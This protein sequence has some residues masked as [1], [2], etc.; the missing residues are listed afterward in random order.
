MLG[1]QDRWQEELFVACSLR[2]LI[3]EDHILKRVE[4]VLDLSWLR[5]EVKDCYCLDNGR[6][7]VDPESAVRLMLA[8]LFQGIIHD[9]KLM[10]EAQVNVAIRW[11]A[12]YRLDEKLPDHS[13]LTKIRRRWGA[14]RFK[15]IFLRTVKACGGAG[16]VS[17]EMTHIDAKL[18][19]AD[20]SWESLVEHH[21][22]RVLEE[23]DMEDDPNDP[24]RR[25]KRG[26]PRTKAPKPKKYS[27]TD[28]DATLTTNNK[29]VRMEPYY[30]QHT[31]VDDQAG[32]VVDV[33]VTTGQANEGEQL[34]EQIN[35]VEANT[36]RKV[37]AVT[38]DASY[39]HSKN[40]LALENRQIDAV[41]PPQTESR[42]PKRIPI[43]R[44]KY[45][46]RHKVVRCPGG[47]VLQ[48]SSYTSKRW[49]YRAATAD[50]RACPLRKRC[51]SPS[52]SSRTIVIAHGYEALLRAR[53]RKAIGW[54]KPTR[55]AYCRHR[56]RAE[57]VHGEAAK[58]HNLGRAHRRRLW[59]VRIQA[60]LTAAVMNLKRLAA[61]RIAPPA[62]KAA[63][64]RS[65]A[66]LL[67]LLRRLRS[68]RPFA[69]AH[70]LRRNHFGVFELTDPISVRLAA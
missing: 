11:F 1:R 36:A 8:G 3:P 57:G 25:P 51:L 47:K 37:K 2:D 18:I 49:L 63:I 67:R 32:V 28:P 12:G 56:W 46:G 48:R 15:A 13:S 70:I 23:N 43:R 6:P 53:R 62:A 7:G 22:E 19:R 14:E 50:C 42:N 45:D 69:E 30:K 10:R 26:R 17:G 64:Q 66:A 54:D 16:L 20:V 52:A 21:A 33:E 9:R 58:W 65:M 34:V 61:V 68:R 35:R 29:R 59:N 40:Y 44:F 41:I 27:K 39:A 5:D 60:Y 55:R 4:K 31:A 38:A 24:S